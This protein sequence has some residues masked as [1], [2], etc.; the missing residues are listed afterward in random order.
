MCAHAKMSIGRLLR[1]RM[2]QRTTKIAPFA[3]VTM[4]AVQRS[5]RDVSCSDEQSRWALSVRNATS[6]RHRLFQ[7]CKYAADAIVLYLRPAAEG[8]RVRPL[9]TILDHCNGM[10]HSSRCSCTNVSEIGTPRRSN[11]HLASRTQEAHRVENAA[12][13]LNRNGGFRCALP[14][15]APAA[16]PGTMTHRYQT[17]ATLS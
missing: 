7:H 6:S 2:C 1:N 12:W 14:R 8:W 16:Q 3:Y 9:V 4:P 5:P 17:F 10:A 11:Q 15:S 13:S